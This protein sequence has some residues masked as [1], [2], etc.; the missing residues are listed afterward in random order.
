MFADPNSRR[1]RI[2]LA[3]KGIDVPTEQVDLGKLE[4]KSD[5]FSELNP[6]QRVPVLVMDDGFCLSESVA[7]CRY[8]EE[9][10]PDPPLM[11]RDAR[12]R[13]I[14][15]MWQ[16]RMELGFLYAVMHTFRHT[17]PHM[18]ELEV[19]QVAEWGAAN[20]PRVLDMLE[21]LDAELAD[22]PFIAGD[23]FSIADIT[24]LVA[25]DFMKPAKIDR[26]ESLTNLARWYE[27]VSSRPS[28]TA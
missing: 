1:V 9:V 10:Q 20:R 15:E 28:A 2:F 5:E 13:A 25:S 3:E 12:E 21:F 27:V 26:P 11:G 19:P 24:T 14:V 23:A 7:I 8:F 4:H 22:R 18:A 17:H 16:R 6:L